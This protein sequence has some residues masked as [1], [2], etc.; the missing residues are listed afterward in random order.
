ML[1]TL[2]LLAHV[3]GALR[4]KPGQQF[5]RTPEWF[6]GRTVQSKWKPS[7]LRKILSSVIITHVGRAVNNPEGE[8]N[9]EGSVEQFESALEQLTVTATATPKAAR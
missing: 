3:S 2:K 4:N 7:G 8:A 5:G 9:L 6:A 1:K